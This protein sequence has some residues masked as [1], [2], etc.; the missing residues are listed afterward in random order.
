MARSSKI[1]FRNKDLVE[2]KRL[3]HNVRNKQSRI[4]RKF[5]IEVKFN[6]LPIQ[7]VKAGSRADFN[8]YKR[9]LHNFTNRNAHRY[10]RVNKILSVPYNEWKEYTANLAKANKIRKKYYDKYKD[11]PLYSGGKPV[12][13]SV[14][15]QKGFFA[16]T[17]LDI[18]EPLSE[19][20]GSMRTMRDFKYRYNNAKRKSNKRLVMKDLEQMQLN[21]LHAFENKLFYTENEPGE[22]ARRIWNALQDMDF[23]T[24]YRIYLSEPKMSFD[25]LYGTDDR[26]AT[27]NVI[28]SA[29]Q[30]AGVYKDKDD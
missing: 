19:G 24:F 30:R 26:Q 15:Q 1:R 29:F 20:R 17:G 14:S 28:D 2:L 18:F 4:R 3:E 13:I 6:Y 25:F 10:Y 8:R 12:G 9:E 27:I 22:D 11:L 23:D 7:E 5:G 21:Y 16:R